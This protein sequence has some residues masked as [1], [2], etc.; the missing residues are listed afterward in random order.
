MSYCVRWYKYN[1]ILAI[2]HV[3]LYD[4]NFGPKFLTHKFVLGHKGTKHSAT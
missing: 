2:I 4:G 3:R 1:K